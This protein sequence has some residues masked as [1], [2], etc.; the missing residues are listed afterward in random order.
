M[1]ISEDCSIYEDAYL[2]ILN[3]ARV[4]LR[5]RLHGKLHHVTVLFM[6]ILKLNKTSYF[7]HNIN[8]HSCQLLITN[9]QK[10]IQQNRMNKVS[11]NDQVPELMV[12]F[13][14]DARFRQQSKISD[15]LIVRHPLIVLA[16][17]Y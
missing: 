7:N 8:C 10:F 9:Q 1:L 5:P 12:N 16:W 3:F 6:L 17:K 15:R 4:E 13:Y 2:P 11:S 14:E